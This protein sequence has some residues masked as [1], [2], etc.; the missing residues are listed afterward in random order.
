M[1]A[2][3]KTTGLS[4]YNTPVEKE[5]ESGSDVEQLEN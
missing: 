2:A 3:A 5:G 1:A 4:Q